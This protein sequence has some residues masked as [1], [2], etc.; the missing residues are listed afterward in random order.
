[1]TGEYSARVIISA[2]TNASFSWGLGRTEPRHKSAK[3]IMQW[4]DVVEEV[5]DLLN[6]DKCSIMAHSAGA[7]YALSFANK[8]SHRICGD[9]C[10]LAPWI[11]G[12]EG[13]EFIGSNFY[14]QTIFISLS[15]TGGY[16]W[17]KYVPNGILKTAQAAEWRIQAWMIGKPPTV[18]YEGIGY[19]VPKDLKH[20]VNLNATDISGTDKLSSSS[21]GSSTDILSEYDDLHDFEGRFESRSTLGADSIER[22]LFAAKS[23]GP[24][25]LIER[26]KAPQEAKQ[27]SGNVGKKLKGLRSL[28]SLKGKG[29]GESGPPSPIPSFQLDV[30]VPLDSD[31]GWIK[32][33]ETASQ[34]S[35]GSQPRNSNASQRY[36]RSHGHRSIS[37]TSTK[38]PM[39]MPS[40]PASSLANSTFTASVGPTSSYQVA[41]GNALIAASHAES[42][43]GTHNDL[44]QILNHDNHPWGFSYSNYPHSV[45][46]WYGDKDEKIAENAVRWMERTMGFEKCSVKVVKGADHGLMYR[47]SV[48]VEVFEHLSSW[49][50]GEDIGYFS[51][52][53][54]DLTLSQIITRFTKKKS[55]FSLR[56][57]I[58]PICF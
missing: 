57:Y 44:L 26:L 31:Y 10:L 3:G 5:L 7:P 6:L 50:S 52:I 34:R 4:A 35:T 55:D 47:S 30:Q 21:I 28:G 48:V 12:S 46:V 37:F 2:L 18:A 20:T 29:R 22:K 43:K 19:T 49:R 1:M 13:S 15:P 45:R 36:N 40:S 25:G 56:L 39:S 17:L 42:A 23:K 16:K 14:S 33:I 38:T 11:G 41:L 32:S 54:R 27:T 53:D 24:R 58:L 9:V 8:F 51:L